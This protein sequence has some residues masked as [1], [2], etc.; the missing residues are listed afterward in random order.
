MNKGIDTQKMQEQVLDELD[1]LPFDTCS[2]KFKAMSFREV[3]LMMI[4]HNPEK[5][6]DIL[7]ELVKEG[8]ENNEKISLDE[9]RKIVKKMPKIQI[10]KNNSFGDV[11]VH[12]EELIYPGELLS[13]AEKFLKRKTGITK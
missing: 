4:K 13:R 11:I 12:K 7:D 9:L 5:L 10:E 6:A 1:N 2:D 3:V 8:K